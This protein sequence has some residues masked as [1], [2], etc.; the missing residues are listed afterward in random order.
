MR[1]EFEMTQD[2]LD[3]LL[4]A[5][6][7]VPA[8]FVSGGAIGPSPQDNANSAWCSLGTKMGFDGKTAEPIHGTCARHFTAEP[9]IPAEEKETT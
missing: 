1:K 2:D 7:P 9:T 6:K 4:A 5:C 3:A 8:L